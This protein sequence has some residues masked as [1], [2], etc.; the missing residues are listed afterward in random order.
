MVHVVGI[1]FVGLRF[2]TTIRSKQAEDA[3]EA[4]D[5]R[6]SDRF[7]AQQRH[8]CFTRASRRPHVLLKLRNLR[9]V[10]PRRR[11]IRR[12]AADATGILGSEEAAVQLCGGSCRRLTPL[13]FP[14][15]VDE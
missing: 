6:H 11:S 10:K 2:S 13:P 9:T 4:A 7:L 5:H 14:A 12:P 3:E 1:R 8:P 15:A